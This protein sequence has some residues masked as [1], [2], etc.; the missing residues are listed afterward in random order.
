[1][2]LAPAEILAEGGAIIVRQCTIHAPV[3][4]PFATVD[5]NV[6]ARKVI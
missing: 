3:H 6:D 1:M 5:G 4:T 2:A